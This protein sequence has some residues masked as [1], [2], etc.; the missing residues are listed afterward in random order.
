M[1]ALCNDRED[2]TSNQRHTALK[3][4]FTSALLTYNQNAHHILMDIYGNSKRE[5]KL[6]H[7]RDPENNMQQHFQQKYHHD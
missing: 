4:C 3:A 2:W 7:Y 5:Q 6:D 1:L